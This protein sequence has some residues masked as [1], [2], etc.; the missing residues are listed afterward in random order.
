MITELRS[1]IFIADENVTSQNLKECGVTTVVVTTVKADIDIRQ[2][3]LFF[4]KLNRPE[5]G[6]NKPHTKDLACHIV[7]HCT[8]NGEVVAIVGET[9]LV[10]AAF[11]AARAVCELESK[12]IYDIFL[13]MQESVKGFDIGKAYL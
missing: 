5:H 9:G 7:K 12:S 3:D 10:R 2:F 4:V 11:V 13:E 1:N 6:I 8:Q